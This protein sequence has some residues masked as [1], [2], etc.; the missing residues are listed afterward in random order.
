MTYLVPIDFDWEG[1][2]TKWDRITTEM[3]IQTDSWWVGVL[4]YNWVQ[5]MEIDGIY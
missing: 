4:Q 2:I 3:W 5:S 1:E